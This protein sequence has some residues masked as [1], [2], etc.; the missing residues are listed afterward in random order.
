MGEILEKKRQEMLDEIQK[1]NPG[2]T[3]CLVNAPLLAAGEACAQMGGDRKKCEE[4]RDKFNQGVSTF[5]ETQDALKAEAKNDIA[6]DVIQQA[7]EF[8]EKEYETMKKK[9]AGEPVEEDEGGA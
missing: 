5:R 9:A 2:C 8:V 1:V 6:A 7:G 4:I 3:P